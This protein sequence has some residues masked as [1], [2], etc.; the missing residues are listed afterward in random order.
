M[1]R[2]KRCRTLLE[3]L[4]IV[5]FLEM[6]NLDEDYKSYEVYNYNIIVSIFFH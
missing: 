5:H 2:E 4:I 6:Q 1:I 3:I